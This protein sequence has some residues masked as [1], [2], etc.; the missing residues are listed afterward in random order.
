MFLFKKASFLMH[1]KKCFCSD[2]IFVVAIL[3]IAI[4]FTY[5]PVERIS[6]SLQYVFK[7]LNCLIPL[8]QKFR[9]LRVFLCLNQN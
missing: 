4:P 8:I 9:M 7:D 5:F 3:D 2:V 1:S 6:D